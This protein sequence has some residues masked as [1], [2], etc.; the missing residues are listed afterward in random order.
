MVPGLQPGFVLPYLAMCLKTGPGAFWKAGLRLCVAGSHTLL[1]AQHNIK[2]WHE[3]LDASSMRY[4]YSESGHCWIEDLVCTCGSVGEN[5][6]SKCGVRTES[7]R[8]IVTDVA[9]TDAIRLG[10]R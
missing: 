5:R 3:V 4:I 9:T 10:S 7:S 6:S 8:H 2:G 1:C